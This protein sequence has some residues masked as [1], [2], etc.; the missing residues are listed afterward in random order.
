MIGP[1]NYEMGLCDNCLG[2]DQDEDPNLCRKCGD[3]PSC[4]QCD[5][6]TF[7][8]L[9]HENRQAQG[10]TVVQC[11]CGSYVPCA[12]PNCYFP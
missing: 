8:L 9:P 10:T 3:C 1:S 6:P 5:V 11:D 12:L 7:W 4:C 2:L